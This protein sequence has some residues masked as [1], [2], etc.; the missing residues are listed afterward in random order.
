VNRWHKELIR[1]LEAEGVVLQGFDQRANSVALDLELNGQTRRYFTGIS[2]SDLRAMNNAF[3]D[4]LRM[5]RAK[6]PFNVG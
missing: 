6:E 4:I 1:R 2:P 5:L 3:H